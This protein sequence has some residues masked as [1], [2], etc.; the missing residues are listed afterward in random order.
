[1]YVYDCCT[2]YYKAKKQKFLTIIKILLLGLLRSHFVRKS[3]NV[4]FEVISQCLHQYG[5][6]LRILDHCGEPKKIPTWLG[7]GPY[8]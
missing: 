5:I 3:Q 2:I 7:P 1:M 6:F 4:A 8:V